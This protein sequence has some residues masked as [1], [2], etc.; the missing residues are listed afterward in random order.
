MPFLSGSG[1]TALTSSASEKPQEVGIVITP[2]FQMKKERLG[3]LQEL[4]QLEDLVEFGSCAVTP[5]AQVLTNS[6]CLGLL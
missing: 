3:D 2:I 1:G 5:G 4:T 6:T